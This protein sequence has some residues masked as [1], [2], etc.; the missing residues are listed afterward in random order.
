MS[1]IQD[2]SAHTTQLRTTHLY[3]WKKKKLVIFRV[4][5]L[6]FSAVMQFLCYYPLHL[7]SV[8][9]LFLSHCTLDMSS[10]LFP[11]YT[12]YISIN[13]NCLSPHSYVYIVSVSPPHPRKPYP[14]IIT[15][16][17]SFTSAIYLHP[18]CIFPHLYT[19]SN[20]NR[21]S[22][23]SHKPHHFVIVVFLLIFFLAAF[24]LILMHHTSF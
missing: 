6:H 17:L 3:H 8:T 5:W 20:Y 22:P 15:V 10:F 21:L 14:L 18:T 11:V 12:T 2:S 4:Y 7:Y 19:P 23:R 9:V 13:R 16:S 24:L 1:L